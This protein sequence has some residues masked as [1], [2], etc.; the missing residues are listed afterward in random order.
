MQRRDKKLLQRACL[1]LGT[2]AI[3]VM[4]TIVRLRM[5][6]ISAGSM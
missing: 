6:P 1:A 5:M 4:S 2:I 3:E